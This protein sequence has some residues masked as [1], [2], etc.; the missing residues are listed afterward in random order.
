MCL[1][2]RSHFI[3]WFRLIY[4]PSLYSETTLFSLCM[5]FVQVTVVVLVVWVRE[6]PNARQCVSTYGRHRNRVVAVDVWDINS[7][8]SLFNSLSDSH[9]A[10]AINQSDPSFI[11]A[12]TKPTKTTARR[13]TQN[14]AHLTQEQSNMTVYILCDRFFLKFLSMILTSQWV[15]VF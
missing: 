15:A 2:Y 7:E 9:D 1:I 13:W 3:F 5:C 12:K 11:I 10:S 6:M 8:K 4:Q 14:S